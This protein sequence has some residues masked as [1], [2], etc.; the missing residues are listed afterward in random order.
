[1]YIVQMYYCT[2]TALLHYCTTKLYFYCTTFFFTA[3]ISTV[4]KTWFGL[5]YCT[6]AFL[7]YMLL[8]CENFITAFREVPSRCQPSH[9]HFM[10]LGKC[11]LLLLLLLLLL[12][13]K[14]NRNKRISIKTLQTIGTCCTISVMGETRIWRS[15]PRPRL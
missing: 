15:R 13:Y 1:M 2:T 8:K 10:E 4:K 9:N 5:Y 3:S 7:F 12:D 11:I 14:M 6:P